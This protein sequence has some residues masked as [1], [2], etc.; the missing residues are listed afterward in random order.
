MLQKCPQ[1]VRRV[2]SRGSR[3]VRPADSRIRYRSQNSFCREVVQFEKFF[4]RPLPIVD[5]RL[6][7]DFPQPIIHLALA[8]S[9]LQMF[10]EF[11]REFFPFLVILRRICPA[12]KDIAVRKIVL[13]RSWLR[14]KRLRHESHFDQR[15]DSFFAK[16][17]ENPVHNFPV[18]DRLSGRILGVC[19]RRTPFQRCGSVAAR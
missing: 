18:V 19:I 6:V 9:S 16:S 2:F 14:G 1:K 3:R 15:R 11:I 10:R 12:R 8:V 17:V 5:V 7:P 4:A 13:V